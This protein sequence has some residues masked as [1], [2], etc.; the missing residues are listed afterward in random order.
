[1]IRQTTPGTTTSIKR[2][3]RKSKPID[4]VAVKNSIPVDS[5]FPLATDEIFNSLSEI[6]KK[7]VYYYY[8][9]PVTGWGQARIYQECS[10][11]ITKASAVVM[12]SVTLAKDD[13]KHCINKLTVLYNESLG[14]NTERILTELAGIAYS[15]ITDYF[16]EKDGKVTCQVNPKNLPPHARRAISSFKEIHTKFETYYE[17]KLWDKLSAIK[18]VREIQ[19]IGTTQRME[20]SGPNGTPIQHQHTNMIDLT[21]L[22]ND[23]IDMLLKISNKINGNKTNDKN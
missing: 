7:F 11:N 21:K 18:Q 2:A 4:K 14:L 8:L 13:V 10:P 9:K 6:E 17:V 3:K 20:L 19:N 15:D 16:E 22:S 23:E 12:A 1:M 5:A